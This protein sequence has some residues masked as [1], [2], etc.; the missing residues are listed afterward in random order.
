M[1]WIDQDPRKLLQRCFIIGLVGILL[2]IIPLANTV[3]TIFD[4]QKLNFL[5]G[6]GLLAQLIALSIAVYV[7][8]MRK[9]AEGPKDKA[10]SMV[11]VLGV[12]LVFFMLR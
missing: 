10:K 6:F 8:R 5:N 4:P 1:S 2:C 7:L 12:A 3:W 9:I 11:I